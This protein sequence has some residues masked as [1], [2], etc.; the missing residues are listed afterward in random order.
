MAIIGQDHNCVPL[1]LAIA[2]RNLLSILAALTWYEIVYLFIPG[3]FNAFNSSSY[4]ASN[5]VITE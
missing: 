5:D 3:L 4:I 1:K 2:A